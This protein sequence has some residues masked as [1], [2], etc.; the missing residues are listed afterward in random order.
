MS[1]PG[2][3]RVSLHVS[4]PALSAEQVISALGLEM[5][6]ARSVGEPR[7]TKGGRE[8]GGAYMRTDVSFIISDGVISNDDILVAESVVRA[9]DVL[10]LQQ[11]NQMVKTGG[12]HASS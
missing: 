8:L 3:Y 10:P 9:L 1:S 5:R 12:A 2:M 6:Y 4:H 7:V 11:I